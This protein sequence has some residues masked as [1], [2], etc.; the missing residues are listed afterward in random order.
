MIQINNRTR[1]V[2]VD[3]NNLAV[4]ELKTVSSP[5]QGTRQEWRRCGYYGSLRNAMIGVLER[6]LFNCTDEELM[7]KQLVNKIETVIQGVLSVYE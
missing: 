7:L 6:E 4:E 5:N 2:K 1:I 3:D